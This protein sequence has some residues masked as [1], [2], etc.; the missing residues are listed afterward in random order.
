V[1]PGHQIVQDQ[2]KV[3]AR[4]NAVS[5]RIPQESGTEPVGRQLGQLLFDAKLRNVVGGDRS[6]VGRLVEEIGASLAV[7]G[8]GRGE[9]EACDSSILGELRKANRGHE[10]DL[11]RDLGIQVAQRVIGER[12]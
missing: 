10:V 4:G 2:L 12:R 7:D 3:V 5:S 6:D 1:R 11:V 9:E 8:A